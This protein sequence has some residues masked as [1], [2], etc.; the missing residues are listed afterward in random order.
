M[1][2]GIAYLVGSFLCFFYCYFFDKFDLLF[3]QNRI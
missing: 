1:L 2:D 3:V